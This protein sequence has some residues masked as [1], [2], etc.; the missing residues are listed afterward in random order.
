MRGLAPAV[1]AAAGVAAILATAVGAGAAA[2]AV[3]A[4]CGRTALVV[5]F[6]PQGH[7]TVRALGFP[8]SR[9]PHV[10]LYRFAGADTY[11]AANFVGSLQAT[12]RP[13]LRCRGESRAMD[14]TS[15]LRPWAQQD[16]KAAV[17]C[18]FL[19]APTVQLARIDG[20]WRARLIEGGR[21]VVLE[22]SLSTVGGS[23][24]GFTPERC[25]SGRAPG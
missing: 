3:S 13:V 12:G 22:A 24:V 15:R 23:V 6:W 10:E 25:R 19:G 9:V 11:R 1:F 8:P 5:L 2:P 18:A 4:S 7:G 21:N 14:D 20:L 17:S 16:G